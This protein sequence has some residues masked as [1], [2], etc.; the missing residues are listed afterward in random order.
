MQEVVSS[1]T[2]YN[3][4]EI[5]P[6]QY[7]LNEWMQQWQ[8]NLSNSLVSFSSDQRLWTQYQ[9]QPFSCSFA[10]FIS[11]VLYPTKQ[12]K[13]DVFLEVNTVV[14]PPFMRGVEGRNIKYVQ[15]ESW[16]LKVY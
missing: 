14:T 3:K 10:K 15:M 2:L 13:A 9:L 5:T 4:N 16:S 12:E 7:H 6:V 1:T 8:T 11:A